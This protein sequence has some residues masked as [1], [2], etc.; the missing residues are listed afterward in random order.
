MGLFIILVYCYARY[1]TTLMSI[2][3]KIQETSSHFPGSFHFIS[4][5]FS[6]SLRVLLSVTHTLYSVNKLWVILT[7]FTNSSPLW[8]RGCSNR[9]I[10]LV[11]SLKNIH[12]IKN[13]YIA[14]YKNRSQ[15]VLVWLNNAAEWW[16][17]GMLSLQNSSLAWGYRL[18]RPYSHQNLW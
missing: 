9:Q 2:S 16:V 10:V 8:R 17:T 15:C 4:G 11:Q 3:I 12:R 1:S 18:R 7:I 6:A 13:N 14:F 5:S